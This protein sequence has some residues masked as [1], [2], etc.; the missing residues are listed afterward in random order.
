VPATRAG[1]PNCRFANRAEPLTSKPGG[2]KPE[3]L[4]FRPRLYEVCPLRRAQ[5]A[6]PARAAADDLLRCR[7][8]SDPYL[9][10]IGRVTKA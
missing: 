2:S 3:G 5:I 1:E 6:R 8:R 7:Y 9:D 10:R 4:G